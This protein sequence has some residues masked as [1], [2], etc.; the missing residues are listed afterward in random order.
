MNALT[1]K[2]AMEN[3]I[4]VYRA[5]AKEIENKYASLIDQKTNSSVDR[6]EAIETYLPALTNELLSLANVL[7]EKNEIVLTEELS[8]TIQEEISAVLHRVIKIDT[9]A[10]GSLN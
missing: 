8:R 9:L 4:E 10:P 2:I 7:F 3:I 6:V 5:E 1:L